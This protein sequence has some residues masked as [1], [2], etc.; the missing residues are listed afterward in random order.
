MGKPEALG[1]SSIHHSSHRVDEGQI[2][3]RLQFVDSHDE[4]P[5]EAKELVQAIGAHILMRRRRFMTHDEL[6]GVV[7]LLGYNP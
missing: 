5:Y 2:G 4:L 3:E 6:R 1:A 7:Q